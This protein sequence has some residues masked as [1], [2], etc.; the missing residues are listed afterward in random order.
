MDNLIKKRL[1]AFGLDYLIFITYALILFI[2]FFPIG[3]EIHSTL[4]LQLL[5]FTT[6]TLPVFLYFYLTE[7]SESR[8]TFGKRKMKIYVKSKYPNNSKN[9]LVRNILKFL[10]WEIAHAGVQWQHHFLINDLNPSVWAWVLLILPQ[11]VV[12]GYFISIIY[13]K[14]ESSIYD[15]L[16]KTTISFR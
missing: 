4:L 15:K 10:P 13:Y 16:A 14:G 6:L 7:K 2:I 1:F 8:A 5:S 12:I 3:L 11:I 9:I